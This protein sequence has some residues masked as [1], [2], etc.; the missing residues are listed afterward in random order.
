[1][2]RSGLSAV[3]RVWGL[4]LLTLLACAAPVQAMPAEA[5]DRLVPVTL[6]LKWRH[7]FQFAGYYA[8]VQQG[9]YR[10][11][12]LEV[13]IREAAEGQ[14]PV[15][16]VLDGAA[17]FGVGG[18][19]LI[20]HYAAGK[21]VVAVAAIFQH[22]PLVLAVPKRAGLESLH[23]LA[24]RPIALEPHSAELEAYLRAE[25]VPPDR[26]VTV[27]YAFDPQALAEG[28]LAALSAYSTDEPFV[29]HKAGIEVSL[30]TPRAAGIDFYGDVLFTSRALA[31]NNPRL[32]QAFLEATRRGWQHALANPE[33]TADLILSR[34]SRRHSREHLLYEAEQMH[35]LILPDLVEIGYMTLGRWQHV[36]KIYGELGLVPMDLPLGPLLFDPDPGRSEARRAYRFTILTALLALAAAGLAAYLVRLNRRLRREVRER[37]LAEDRSRLLLE[38]A[39]LPVMIARLADG[40]LM[41]VNREA[42]GILAI[43]ADRLTGVVLSERFLEARQAEQLLHSLRQQR[44]VRDEEARLQAPGAPP[45]WAQLVA[46]PITY[47]DSPAAFL[48]FAD[49]TARR[50]AQEALREREDLYRQ[51]FE[52]NNAVKLLIDPASGAIVDA[53]K[54]AEEYYGFSRGELLSLK[55]DQINILDH[56]QIAAEMVA[57]ER[58]QRTYFTFPHR[59]KSGAVRDVE[60]YSGPVV[61]GGRRLLHSIIHDVT[62]RNRALAELELKSAALQRSNAELQQFAYVASHDLQE[63]L[64]MV[65]SYLQLI[66]RRL[67]TAMDPEIKEFM[68]FATDGA[69]RMSQ[70]I[71]DLLAF[72]RI[73]A[74][75]AELQPVDLAEVMRSVRANLAAS[76]NEAGAELA[77]EAMPRVMGDPQQLLS[78]MQNLVGNAV[79]Y[80]HPDRASQV[81]VSAVPEGAWWHVTV[82][83]NGIGIEPQ[84]F[85]KIFLIFQ[86]L[87]PSS[88]YQGTGI[89]LALCKK[90]VE[91]LGGR[92][93]VDS[94]PGQG[95]RFHVTLPAA[96]GAVPQAAQ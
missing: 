76:L 82:A 30:F 29:L 9:F 59:L 78:L 48:A 19:D 73:D 23:D 16:P 70:L 21:P 80:R 58:E 90:V 14:D 15:Q 88:R 13:I 22:S 38:T 18:S 43:P 45:F 37:G 64:R 25:G 95:S 7:Q 61:W 56:R 32:V 74:R 71:K 83:D 52:R 94:D 12:G 31:E 65:T 34:Y 66:E 5:A 39:P 86:R 92:I 77:V 54:A 63:P 87:H 33:D 53:N 84:Y 8:A 3:Q 55:I 57:A 42:A 93:W 96:A 72:T 51:M 89:G 20:L 6:Q 67:G 85:D 11:A 50:A 2:R 44:P 75:P 26:I 46:T 49:V 68:G 10:D 91:T 69:R 36:A 81:R 24:G 1:M 79:K 47:R 4:V 40:Q 35:R 60:V 62:E 17:Q 27:P 28:R 41:F